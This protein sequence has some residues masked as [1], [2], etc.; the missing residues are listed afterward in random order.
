MI[1]RPPRS[2][3]FPYTT[4]SR[5]QPERRPRGNPAED[6]GDGEEGEGGGRR[7]TR[8]AVHLTG[9]ESARARDERGA[10]AESLLRGDRAPA[11]RV[12]ARG[13]GH[14]RAGAHRRRREPGAGAGRDAAG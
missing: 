11:A 14:R 8:P 13:E 5:S 12:V 6:R 2:T 4:L 1:R 7:G 10:G 9:Q 3:L